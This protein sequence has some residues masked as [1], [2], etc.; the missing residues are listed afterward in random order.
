M[1]TFHKTEKLTNVAGADKL[2]ITT[3]GL[4]ELV[5]QSEQGQKFFS[6]SKDEVTAL[7]P[8]LKRWIDTDSLELGEE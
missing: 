5:F 3:N 1:T 2:H 6:I 7:L 8:Y 4:L